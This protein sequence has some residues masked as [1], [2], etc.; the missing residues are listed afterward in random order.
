[1]GVRFRHH[2][3]SR[4]LAVP[5]HEKMHAFHDDHEIMKQSLPSHTLPA[6][7][8]LTLHSPLQPI[9]KLL[10]PCLKLHNNIPLPLPQPRLRR[11]SNLNPTPNRPL[12]HLT[13]GMLVSARKRSR[14]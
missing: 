5:E 3:I 9:H 8:T 4:S 12:Q 11:F 6:S 1:M 2:L 14:Y 7:I 10:P 13:T